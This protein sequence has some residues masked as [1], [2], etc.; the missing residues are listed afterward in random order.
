MTPV[1]KNDARRIYLASDAKLVFQEGYD[2]FYEDFSEQNSAEPYLA[3]GCLCVRSDTSWLVH[4]LNAS[5]DP[6]RAGKEIVQHMKTGEHLYFCI[7][8][9]APEK[10]R[11]RAGSYKLA[12]EARTYSDP[13]IR[14]LMPEDAPQIAACCAPDPEDTDIGRRIAKEAL[15]WSED[16]PTAVGSPLGIFRDG[17]LCGF[18]EGRRSPMTGITPINIF[19]KRAYRGQGYAKRLLNAFCARPG[20]VY[21]YSCVKSNLASYRTALSCGFRKVGEYLLIV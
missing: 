21:C 7:L 2:L 13:E 18:V 5:S 1:T 6:V 11:D 4:A 10:L 20:T 8:G 9:D 19:V 12:R 16:P 14:P 15:V 17:T 3:E